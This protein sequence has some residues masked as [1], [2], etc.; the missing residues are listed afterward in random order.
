[1]YHSHADKN[2]FP[3][4]S[5]LQIF[6]GHDFLPIHYMPEVINKWITHPD[7]VVI[8][9]TI[10]TDVERYIHPKC[11]D[12]EVEL[13]DPIKSRVNSALQSFSEEG[14]K[15]I[16][17]LDEEVSRNYSSP[18]YVFVWTDREPTSS[19]SCYRFPTS[20][21]P[22]AMLGRSET[23]WSRLRPTHQPSSTAGLT[24]KRGIFPLHSEESRTGSQG[25]VSHQ[26]TCGGQKCSDCHG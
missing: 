8:R 26:K 20:P 17:S 16:V 22:S 5:S 19:T 11:Y 7:P 4:Y 9:Y 13:D 1:M 14:G 12:F 23:S 21:S 24:R 15:E 18:S 25:R 3:R 2:L 10:K 6:G